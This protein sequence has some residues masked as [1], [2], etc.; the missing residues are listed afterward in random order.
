MSTQYRVEYTILASED[1]FA[2]EQEVGFGSS[3]TWNT[4]DACAHMVESDLQNGT[5]ERPTESR[6]DVRLT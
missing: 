3:G 6:T 2:T 4:V 5:W 1:G